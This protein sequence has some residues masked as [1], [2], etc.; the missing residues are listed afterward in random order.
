MRFFGCYSNLR[1]TTFGGDSSLSLRM[2]ERGQNDKKG[3]Q[4][5]RKGSRMTKIKAE[6]PFLCHPEGF[7]QKGLIKGWDSSVAIATSEWQHSEGILRYR[8]EWQKRRQNDKNKT[9][10]M[11]ERGTVWQKGGRMTFFC[12]LEAFYLSPWGVSR[13]VSLFWFKIYDKICHAWTLLCLHHDE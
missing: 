9:L 10:S 12:H 8:S 4:N 6:W 5:D 1:M 13:R 3:G 2:T 7:S 11:T